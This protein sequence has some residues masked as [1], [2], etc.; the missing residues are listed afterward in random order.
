MKRYYIR[1]PGNFNAYGPIEADNERDAR[2]W[3]RD[4]LKL[5]RLPAGF[6][7]WEA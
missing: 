3:V 6:E 2:A 1:I 7:I 4:W 5:K